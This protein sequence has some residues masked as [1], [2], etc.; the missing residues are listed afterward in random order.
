MLGS[1]GHDPEAGT[2]E[3]EAEDRSVA[4][5]MTS[6]WTRMGCSGVIR[7]FFSFPL[8]V[9]LDSFSFLTLC[10]SS[11]G[12]LVSLPGASGDDHAQVNTLLSLHTSL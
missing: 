12:I 5:G 9:P 6:V 2:M 4:A 3:P 7:N 10:C 8:P 1:S 11:S